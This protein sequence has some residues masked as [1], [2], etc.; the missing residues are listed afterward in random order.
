[1][2]NKTK[3]IISI[4]IILIFI[5]VF[6]RIYYLDTLIDDEGEE[7]TGIVIAFKAKGEFKCRFFVNNRG[8]TASG[9]DGS[10][11][12][13][14]KVK[15]QYY[16]LFKIRYYKRNPEINE[17]IVDTSYFRLNKNVVWTE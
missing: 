13:R 8:Y 9:G 15:F 7:T 2:S 17:V 14:Y 10:F 4:I 16:D 6:G 11:Q 3:Q 12:Y 5:A 1:M